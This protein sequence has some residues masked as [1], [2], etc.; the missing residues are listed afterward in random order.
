[1]ANF[2]EASNMGMKDKLGAISGQMPGFSA[3]D[4]LGRADLGQASNFFGVAPTVFADWLSFLNS[5]EMVRLTLAVEKKA[6]QLVAHRY[7]WGSLAENERY[8]SSI[9]ATMRHFRA[10][11]ESMGGDFF[12][13]KHEL[14]LGAL[15]R[16]FSGRFC[17]SGPIARFN[18]YG[19]SGV[20]KTTFCRM[21]ANG[22]EFSEQH[23]GSM[24]HVDARMKGVPVTERIVANE[25]PVIVDGASRLPESTILEIIEMCPRLI[26]VT[27]R[28]L[29]EIPDENRIELTESTEHL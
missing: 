25:V 7:V 14:R 8:R 4:A 20:G 28:P 3:Y 21:V 10:P 23:I 1:M 11:W 9:G 15:S 12:S 16:R 22:L 5:D 24:Q 17:S 29:P 13:Y 6:I 2:S 18:V 27:D 26:L 19:E